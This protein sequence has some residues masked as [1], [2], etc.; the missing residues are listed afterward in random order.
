MGAGG[1]GADLFGIAGGTTGSFSATTAVCG[2][3]AVWFARGAG[4][5]AAGAGTGGR[6]FAAWGV[7][8]DAAWTETFAGLC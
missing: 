6:T 4:G 5:W 8:C 2:A 1:A 7:C 3:G